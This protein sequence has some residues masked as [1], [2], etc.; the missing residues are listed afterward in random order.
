MNLLYE[1]IPFAHA[2]HNLASR[3]ADLEDAEAA[4]PSTRRTA[5]CEPS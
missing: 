4:A 2:H 5:A 3:A 1:N